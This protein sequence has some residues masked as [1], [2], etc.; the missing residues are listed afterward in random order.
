MNAAV[1][2]GLVPNLKTEAYHMARLQ[3]QMWFDWMD[4]ILDVHRNN[5]VFREATPEELEQHGTAL[6]LA[7]R[8]SNLFHALIADPEFNE[9][10]LVS[11]L[12]VRIRQLQDAYDT[13]HDTGLSDEKAERTLQQVFP[14]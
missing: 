12:K 13:F 7:I 5:F 2:H 10:D 14:E 3:V 9:S 1:A 6:K 4:R 8:H 11:R